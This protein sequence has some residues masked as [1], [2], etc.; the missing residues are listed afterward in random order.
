MH[1]GAREFSEERWADFI[2]N[3]K[4]TPNLYLTLGGDLINNGTRTSVSNI[5]DERLRPSD[6]KKLMA[7]YLMPVKD[8]IL[9]CVAGNHERRSGKDVDDDPCYDIM[10]T[11]DLE[12]LYR[13]NIAFLKIQMGKPRGSG[14][15]NPTYL[16]VVTHGAGGGV[17]SGSAINRNERF[18]YVMD[19]ADALIVGHTHKP[20]VSQPGKIYIDKQHNKVS[21]KPFKVIVASS[22]L[23]YG[24]YAAQK[25]LLPS[26][27]AKQSINLKGNVKEISVSM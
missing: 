24:G 10:A 1:L 8:R 22:W 20:M 17:L 16:L 7:N 19:G 15:T 25:M 14:E 3:V 4:D 9:C 26:S 27:F 13:E 18:G 5:F 11:L 2:S 21:I 6:Q 23:D 12:H